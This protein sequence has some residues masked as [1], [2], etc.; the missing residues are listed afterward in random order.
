MRE[1]DVKDVKEAVKRLCMEAN[2][3]LP[4]DVLSAFREGEKREASEIGRSVLKILQEN[5]RIASAEKLPYCQDTGF[6]VVFLEVGQNVVFKGGDI[7]K[8]INEGV[9]DSLSMH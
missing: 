4:S 1:V 6:A 7:E 8:A 3:N 9:S 2:Y 5:A